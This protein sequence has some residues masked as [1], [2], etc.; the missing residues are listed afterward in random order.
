MTELPLTHLDGSPNWRG[1]VLSA[2]AATKIGRYADALGLLNT[3]MASPDCDD[4][5]YTKLDQWRGQLLR[6][7][8]ESPARGD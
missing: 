7:L 6:N 8:R 2:L 1:Y 4:L 3:V 5:S